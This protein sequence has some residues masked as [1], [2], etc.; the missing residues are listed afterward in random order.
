MTP[1]EQFERL[2]LE[3]I[4]ARKTVRERDRILDI[5]ATLDSH[6]A[7]AQALVA[8]RKVQ[9]RIAWQQYDRPLRLWTPN[10]TEDSPAQRALRK[11]EA[12]QQ[13]IIGLE[14]ELEALESQTVALEEQ[15][16]AYADCEADLELLEGAQ[17]E[18]IQGHALPY[19]VELAEVT[20][21]IATTTAAQFEHKEAHNWL[22]KLQGEVAQISELVANA[23][24]LSKPSFFRATNVFDV[25][26]ELDKVIG[27][28]YEI[29]HGAQ[30]TA[31]RYL[32]EVADTGVHAEQSTILRHPLVGLFHIPFS[33]PQRRQAL[34][35]W[36]EGLRGI[37]EQLR[38]Q[39]QQLNI[40][41]DQLRIKHH[42]LTSEREILLN[43][44]WRPD[45]L[46]K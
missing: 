32:R 5:L 34:E 7:N 18:F 19:S 44:I 46:D 40:A 24:D 22:T 13:E 11:Y 15:L 16:I 35:V 26:R 9:A 25:Q 39:K 45:N 12:L 17:F 38:Q 20:H 36:L 29:N 8:E 4:A 1:R 31:K 14:T 23:I 43:L 30:I 28:A 3:L 10:M 33:M 42:N 21:S 6:K 27:N 41:T 37:A 2:N